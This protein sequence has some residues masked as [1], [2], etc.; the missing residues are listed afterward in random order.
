MG[1]LQSSFI[2]PDDP[3]RPAHKSERTMRFKL[4][5]RHPRETAEVMESYEKETDD[6]EQWSRDIIDWFN[7]TLRRG[8]RKREFIRCEIEGEVPPAE[9]KWFKVTAMTKL[10]RY[11][12]PYDAMHCERCGVTGKRFGIG[13]HVK[14]DSKF[15]RKAFKR[16]DTAVALLRDEVRKAEE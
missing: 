4:F 6:P 11:G 5:W 13:S 10:S 7:S 12:T 2:S 8:E 9:H 16:C 15:R 1:K 3:P 14:L